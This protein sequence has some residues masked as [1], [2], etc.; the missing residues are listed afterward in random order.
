MV[1]L[2][3]YKTVSMQV[4]PAGSLMGIISTLLVYV[5]LEWKR[6]IHPIYEIGKL[7]TMILFGL[8]IGL[9]PYVDNFANI[10]GLI[11]GVLLSAIFVPYYPP[12]EGEK[13]KVSKDIF[14]K[15]KIL[16]VAICLPTFIAIFVIIFVLFYVVQ[17]NCS[18]CQYITCIPFT[19]TI[20]Q[21]QRPSP[22]NRD[23]N[24]I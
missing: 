2:A 20:C 8:L 23:I 13:S 12:Y 9:L 7:A 15:I 14:R 19:D 6:F 1:L 17:P 18:G 16:L 3:C 22:D 10:G 4:G 5:L 21:D 11:T 24:L